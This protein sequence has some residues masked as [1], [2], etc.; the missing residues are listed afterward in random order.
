[1]N[2]LTT[3]LDLLGLLALVAAGVVLIAPL[4]VAGAIA[5]GAAGTLAVSW[6]IDRRAGRPPRRPS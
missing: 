5:A 2:I 1:M 3:V 6:L 4:T